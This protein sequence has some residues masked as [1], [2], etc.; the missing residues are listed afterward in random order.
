MRIFQIGD[1]FAIVCESKST[2]NG[3]KHEAT[4][5]TGGVQRDFSKRNYLNRT[6]ERFEYDSVIKDLVENTE[7]LTDKEKELAREFIKAR[8]N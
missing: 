5:L 1:R 3:F 7:E 4:L 8:T 6:W 2:R